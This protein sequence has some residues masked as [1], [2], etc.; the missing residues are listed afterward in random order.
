MGKKWVA[1]SISGVNSKTPAFPYSGVLSST[2]CR[3]C[4]GPQKSSKQSRQ[5][6][7]QRDALVQSSIHRTPQSRC[8][9]QC[10]CF[11]AHMNFTPYPFLLSEDRCLWWLPG[12]WSLQAL[13]Q[14][15]L[16]LCHVR[17]WGRVINPW[18]FELAKL[19]YEPC[20]ATH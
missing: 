12:H 2:M 18:A 5:N 8:E 6:G 3:V 17:P 11:Q 4:A 10:S 9:A 15:K 14:Y 19:G 13:S 16:S 1:Q 7:L 20:L